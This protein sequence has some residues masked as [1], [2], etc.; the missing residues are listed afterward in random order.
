MGQYTQRHA[1]VSENGAVSRWAAADEDLQKRCP[2]L[3][4][5]LTEQLDDEG[6]PRVTSTLMVSCE[7]GRWKLCLTDRAQAGGK[8]DYKL[9][10]SGET[11][12]E[13]FSSL[14]ASLAEANADWR[15]FP[16]WEQPKRR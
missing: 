8:F 1:S 4:E 15:R 14:D 5:F 11:L 13:A 12:W 16:R 7:D 3:V 2:A 6:K 9:W 10:V